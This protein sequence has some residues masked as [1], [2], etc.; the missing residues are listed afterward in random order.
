MRD[1]YCAHCRILPP[2]LLRTLLL[3]SP[4]QVFIP[5]TRLCRDSCGYCTFAQPLQPG[6]R[7]YMTLQ[8]VL[9]VAQLGAEQGCTEA[10]FT[11]GEQP[12]SSLRAAYEQPMHAVHEK[13]W[14]TDS[15]SLRAVGFH[16]VASK[17]IAGAPTEV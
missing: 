9:Q 15:Q 11:L 12:T 17:S 7:A 5:L 1:S 3:P 13:A 10:L 6:R 8:E 14:R 16:D 2:L 4:P